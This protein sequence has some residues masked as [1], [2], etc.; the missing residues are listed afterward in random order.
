MPPPKVDLK[1]GDVI[2]GIDI[3]FVNL[4]VCQIHVTSL[5]GKTPF[6]ITDWKLI[7]L[8]TTKISEACV[9]LVDLLEKE[10]HWAASRY[11]VIEHQSPK[12][13]A[14]NV[15]LAHAMQVGLLMVAKCIG[16]P[17]PTIL[18]AAPKAKFA[19]L[20]KVGFTLQ[21]DEQKE[22]KESQRKKARKQNAVELSHALLD[23][24]QNKEYKQQLTNSKV[25]EKDD[26]ADAMV[27][28]VGFIYRNL[29]KPNKS[30]KMQKKKKSVNLA[31]LERLEGEAELSGGSSDS[32]LRLP[33]ETTA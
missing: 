29:P 19:P 8:G 15:A 31:H 12:F 7:N 25:G 28:A 1:I 14:R 33:P 6:A 5:E 30:K 16:C 24:L 26:L 4:A 3:G 27:Y 18:F 22:T 21:H 9:K 17:M 13:M 11:I 10:A 32:A 23:L 2:L 20:I